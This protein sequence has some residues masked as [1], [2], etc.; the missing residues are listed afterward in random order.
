MKHFL[1]LTVI[2]LYSSVFGQQID[3]GISYDSI[4][5][6][7]GTDFQLVYSKGKTWLYD[8]KNKSFLIE[9]SK[10]F[11]YYFKNVRTLMEMDA[12]GQIKVYDL[13]QGFKLDTICNEVARYIDNPLFGRSVYTG[14]QDIYGAENYFG[15]EK[16][17][18]YLIVHDVKK[19]NPRNYEPIPLLNQYGEDSVVIQP[20]GTSSLVYLTESFENEC[21]SSV[22]DMKNWQWLVPKKYM[23]LQ[24]LHSNLIV[25]SYSKDLENSEQR[26]DYLYDFFEIDAKG[27]NKKKMGVDDQYGV[28][29]E[30]ILN[31]K[32]YEVQKEIEKV[33]FRKEGQ[34]GLVVFAINQIVYAT[35][36]SI[37]GWWEFP[38]NFK[39]DTVAY[40]KF[41]W[42]LSCGQVLNGAFYSY[43][44][45]IKLKEWQ[46][47]PNGAK[48]IDSW[49]NAEQSVYISSTEYGARSYCLDHFEWDRVEVTGDQYTKTDRSC[50]FNKNEMLG[51]SVLSDSSVY[52]HRYGEEYQ[53]VIPILDQYGEDSIS[54]DG[55][56]VLFPSMPGVYES[57]VYNF[58][59]RKWVVA[60]TNI[61]VLPTGQGFLCE[62][63]VLDSNLNLIETRFKLQRYDGIMAFEGITADELFKDHKKEMVPKYKVDSVYAVGHTHEKYIN[64]NEVYFT[65]DNKIGVANLSEGRTLIEPSDYAYLDPQ[66]RFKL[67]LKDGWLH[68]IRNQV[69][70]TVNMNTEADFYWEIINSNSIGD[71][72]LI[73]HVR[74]TVHFTTYN[75]ETF[76]KELDEELRSTNFYDRTLV[77]FRKVSPELIYIEN[78]LADY[79]DPNLLPLSEW[80]EPQYEFDENGNT[81]SILS[82]GYQRSG[83]YNMKSHQWIVPQEYEQMLGWREGLSLWFAKSEDRSTEL[84]SVFE[85]QKTILKDQSYLQI[86]TNKDL[87]EKVSAQLGVDQ[88]IYALY[89]TESVYF[90]RLYYYAFSNGKVGI[91]DM[92]KMNYV[93][94]FSEGL[95]FNL[96]TPICATLNKDTL[97]YNYYLFGEKEATQ[98]FKLDPTAT[99]NI[100]KIH[101]GACRFYVDQIKD[102]LLITFSANELWQPYVTMWGEDSLDMEGNLVGIKIDEAFDL[103]GIYSLKEGKWLVPQEYNMIL[104]LPNG[105]IVGRKR[106]EGKGDSEWNYTLFNLNGEILREKARIEELPE[107]TRAQ[108]LDH[109]N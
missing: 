23:N 2:L 29:W 4:Q 94:P 37:Q 44:G 34:T 85:Q 49:I 21:R 95:F 84:Y 69:E 14:K 33:I 79:E 109:F 78:F 87:I 32:D 52:L 8:L 89:F 40:G 55:E 74:N 67:Y 27:I 75:G 17:G 102:Q 10:N 98:V 64:E 11:I 66:G 70:F 61:S 107:E 18:K 105:E 103:S 53:S 43:D 83:L 73:D 41:D 58:K 108:I 76:E 39:I 51:L 106:G 9:K 6:C 93:V 48:Y 5:K 47:D 92:Q 68:F 96:H 80:G 72:A 31:T 46:D 57:G 99:K 88:L 16:S 26:N 77:A 91:F 63:P 82:Q 20:D 38:Y 35:D 15:F 12:S 45:Q 62:Y 60:P 13:M 59:T 81:I 100:L 50:F 54:A 42:I 86:L 36:Y 22:F 3:L 71:V 90:N 24:F 101:K 25:G 56:V 1:Q 65:T 104:Q 97:T 19:F 28:P 7:D 30:M